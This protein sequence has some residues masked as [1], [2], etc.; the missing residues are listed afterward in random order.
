MNKIRGEAAL[1]A[2][3]LQYRLLLTLDTELAVQLRSESKV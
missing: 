1:D 2:G 3:G